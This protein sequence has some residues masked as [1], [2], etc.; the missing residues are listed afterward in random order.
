MFCVVELSH[1]FTMSEF[2]LISRLVFI[3]VWYKAS[4]DTK[5]LPMCIHWNESGNQKKTW[6]E[7]R[8]AKQVKETESECVWTLGWKKGEQKAKEKVL[9]QLNKCI[10]PSHR[11]NRSKLNRQLWL[12]PFFLLLPLQWFNAHLKEKAKKRKK[13][14]NIRMMMNKLLLVRWRWY[15]IFLICDGIIST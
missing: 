12:N 6:L 10:Q 15:T 14:N 3:G 13:N 7:M 2:Y 8:M 1:S 5:S 4:A 9:L 11:S